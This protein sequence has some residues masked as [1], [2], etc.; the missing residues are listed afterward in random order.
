MSEVPLY[1]QAWRCATRNSTGVPCI[2]SQYTRW[3]TTLSP[4]GAKRSSSC[5][6][7]YEMVGDG[8]QREASE[9]GEREARARERR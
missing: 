9:S 1:S 3:T 8:V 5:V 6:A 2:D 4:E 7:S